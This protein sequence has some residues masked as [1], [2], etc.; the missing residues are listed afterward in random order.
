LKLLI[1]SQYF[2]PEN[3]KIN[4]LVQELVARGHEV[5]VLTGQPNYPE[6]KIFPDFLKSPG[7][8]ANYHGVRIVRVPLL[9]RGSGGAR[10][11]LNYL[12]FAIVAATLGPVKLR[13]A[14]FDCIFAFEPS[15]VTVGIP[16]IVMRRLRRV[17]VAF[18]VQDLWPETLQAIGVVT[19]PR[20]LGWIGKLVKFIYNR[21]D[22][23]LAQS[24]GFIPLIAGNCDHPERIKYF[25]NWAEKIFDSVQDAPAPEVPAAEGKFSIMFA[26]NIGEAQDFPAIL[27][28]AEQLRGQQNIRW[29]IVGEGRM[30]DW[31]AGEIERRGLGNA[32]QMLGRF[33]MERMPSFYRH[34]DALL[35][36]LKPNPVMAMTIPAKLQ[37][38]LAAGVPV[39]AM[40]DG[41]GAVLVER[42][43]A[44]LA[45]A[46]GDADGLARAV[47]RMSEMSK[48][49]RE[50][51]GQRGRD[52]TAAEF[53]RTA[54]IDKLE[55][56]LPGLQYSAATAR[57]AA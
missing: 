39:L 50:T 3:F 1:I 52:A 4:D 5:T 21:C 33:P 20:L 31:V 49:E 10:L 11:V 16:A 9:A 53:D 41:E 42:T 47:V 12:S 26:G 6:G 40:I 46:A 45:C 8:Y 57:E 25:P 44:G 38:Y 19:S 15:P 35:V 43:G 54:Q 22:L 37:T 2:W 24:Q 48:Q 18:W 30:S 51:M 27:D 36:S 28:A 56:W 7:K 23:I 32:V 17:P 29:L 55:S 14:A 34:A 13:N